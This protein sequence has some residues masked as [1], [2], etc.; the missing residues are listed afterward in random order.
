MSDEVREADHEPEIDSQPVPS[1]EVAAALC[2]RFDGS[3]FCESHGQSVVYLDAQHWAPAAQYLRDHERFTMC[4]DITAVDHLTTGVRSTPDGVVAQRFEM[5]AN[6]LSHVRNRRIRLMTQLEATT[7]TIASLT[8]IYPGCNFPERETFDLLG[9]DF[10]GHPE[11]T[12]IQMP[13]EWE[14]HPLRKDYA[15]ARVP[16]TFKGDPSPR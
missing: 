14:G 9:I 8:P 13:E 16:V 2:A 3:V 6:F 7:P 11:L 15:P 1:D 12:R 10:V 5:V 4:V